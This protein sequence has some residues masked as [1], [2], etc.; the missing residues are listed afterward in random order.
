[1]Q[2]PDDEVRTYLVYL[3]Y[4]TLILDPLMIY[5]KVLSPL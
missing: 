4:W 5:P 2:C 3:K 1:M